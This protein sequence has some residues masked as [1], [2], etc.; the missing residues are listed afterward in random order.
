MSNIWF[1]DSYAK[2]I[3]Y[4]TFDQLKNRNGPSDQK[5]YT[6]FKLNFIEHRMSFPK[7]YF[8]VF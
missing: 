8:R 3:R 2:G 1:S 4:I 5:G 6:D 7:A